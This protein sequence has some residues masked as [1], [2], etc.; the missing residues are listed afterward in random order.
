MDSSNSPSTG[1]IWVVEN[2]ESHGLYY[3]NFQARKATE[4]KWRSWKVMG[5]QYYTLGEKKQKGNKIK[6]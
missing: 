1:F 2:L 3:F 4:F 5:K 6:K